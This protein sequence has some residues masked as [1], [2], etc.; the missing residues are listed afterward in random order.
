[1]RRS[2]TPRP[3]RPDFRARPSLPTF[4]HT[5]TIWL[6][7][8]CFLH[9]HLLSLNSPSQPSLVDPSSFPRHL[10]EVLGPIVFSI[11]THPLDDLVSLL[12]PPSTRSTPQDQT[13]ILNS[14][15]ISTNACAA[16][17][18]GC[19]TDILMCSELNF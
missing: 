15:L 11:Y 18:I 13:K 4:G 9:F 7:G 5:L 12:V 8:H 2:P 6:L 16:P 1:M 10:T 3:W 19:T 17:P 14:R